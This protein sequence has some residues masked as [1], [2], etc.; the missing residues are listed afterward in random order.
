MRVEERERRGL[1]AEG[2]RSGEGIKAVSEFGQLAFVQQRSA[3][4]ANLESYGLSTNIRFNGQ[5]ALPPSPT[6]L[7]ISPSVSTF[8]LGFR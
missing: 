4:Y 6:S 1:S 2:T 7:L 5:N 3:A 8:V